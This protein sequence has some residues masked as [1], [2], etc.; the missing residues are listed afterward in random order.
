MR[1]RRGCLRLA[2]YDV[3]CSFGG[4]AADPAV[5]SGLTSSGACAAR[6]RGSPLANPL[7]GIR[8]GQRSF[9][10]VRE[11]GPRLLHRAWERAAAASSSA[12]AGIMDMVQLI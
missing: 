7:S 9:G 6:A 12:E 2:V 1:F 4:V 11:S 5:N 8:R 3:V 10:K